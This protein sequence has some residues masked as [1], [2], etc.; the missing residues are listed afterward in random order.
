MT[1]LNQDFSWR[2]LGTLLAKLTYVRHQELLVLSI[3]VLVSCSHGNVHSNGGPGHG[4]NSASNGL[5]EAICDAGR[6]I[7][8]VDGGLPAWAVGLFHASLPSCADATNLRVGPRADFEWAITGCDFF[9]GEIGTAT[10][11]ADTVVLH[12]SDQDSSMSWPHNF[13]IDSVPTVQLI[14]RLDGGVISEDQYGTVE[15]LPGTECG[16]V[17][18]HECGCDD[19]FSPNKVP[20]D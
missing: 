20:Q 4:G 16:C 11:T 6:D 19:P 14:K 13:E 7:E 3:T 2:V 1:R 5:D 17:N 9:A 18:F 15:W 8:P 10:T 12:S